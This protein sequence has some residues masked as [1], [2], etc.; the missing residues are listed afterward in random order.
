MQVIFGPRYGFTKY[1]A[2]KGCRRVT[3]QVP[4]NCLPSVQ[5]HGVCVLVGI[6]KQN[7]PFLTT[8]TITTIPF[9][10]FFRTLSLSFL[11]YFS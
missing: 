7:H 4:K 6:D 5:H 1:G 8:T 11:F 2:I 9:L 10:L 3:S